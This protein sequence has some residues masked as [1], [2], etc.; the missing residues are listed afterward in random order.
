M[1]V[2]VVVDYDDLLGLRIQ[3]I[4]NAPDHLHIIQACPDFGDDEIVSRGERIE[5][6][7]DIGNAVAHV[8]AVH[9]FRMVESAGGC[10]LPG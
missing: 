8:H 5:N 7:E 1:C 3:V 6:H 10:R 4:G 2:Q 9:F